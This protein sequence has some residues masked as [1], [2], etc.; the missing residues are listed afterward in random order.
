M[1]TVSQTPLI[2]GL[3]GGIGSGKSAVSDYFASL[4]IQIVDADMIAHALTAAGSSV[5]ERLKMAFGAWVVDDKG[6]YDRAKMRAYVFERPHALAQLN[7]IMHPAIHQQI[8]DQLSQA[9]SPYAILSVPLLFEG[10]HKTPNLLS[11]CHHLLIV[12]VPVSVQLTRAS[13]RDANAT[14]QIQAIIDK[15]I[16]RDERL[17]LAKTLG[18]DV[19]DNTG[20]LDELYA[21][22]L[23]LHERYLSMAQTSQTQ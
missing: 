18:A 11:L 15:Q 14:P 10:R 1:H 2:I 16:S 3:T 12:D 6:N 21:K 22:L 5:L 20:S 23:R 17:S 8:L 7:A 19:I 9:T 13:R 4:G